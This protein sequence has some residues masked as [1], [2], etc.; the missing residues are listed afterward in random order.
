MQ[1]D[2]TGHAKPGDSTAQAASHNQ[3]IQPLLTR[4]NHPAFVRCYQTKTSGVQLV[5]FSWR[6]FLT[7]IGCIEK[8][9]C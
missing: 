8:N 5:K 4:P 9:Y 7:T 1:I 6:N 2:Q 3:Q